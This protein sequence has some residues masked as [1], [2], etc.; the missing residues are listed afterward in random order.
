MHVG[1]TILLAVSL[2]AIMGIFYQYSFSGYD[3]PVYIDEPIQKN[4]YPVETITIEGDRGPVELDL[5]ATYKVDA[6][7]KNIADYSADYTSQ[8]SPR[9]FALAWADINLPGIDKHVTYSQKNR[10][11]Y[12]T[13]VKNNKVDV[14]YVDRNSA[15]THLIPSN[16][17][18]AALIAEVEQDDFI[19]MEGFLVNANF[20]DGYWN[21]SLTRED[22]GD[23]SCEIMY[24]TSLVFNDK[25]R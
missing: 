4:L 7:V 2:L 3:G 6:V 12:F 8:I 25:E 18:V 9:D 20:K 17:R 19:T 21:T 14:H 16:D 11:Y 22:T 10:W 23:G 5:L 1:K 13:V 15:N 24:V